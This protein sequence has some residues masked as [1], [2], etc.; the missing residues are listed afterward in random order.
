[1]PALRH[2]SNGHMTMDKW[3]YSSG[4][5]SSRAPGGHYRGHQASL[6]G[7]VGHIVFFA[8]TRQAVYNF[9]RTP[10]RDTSP[11]RPHFLMIEL[12]VSAP[13]GG[14]HYRICQGISHQARYCTP[15]GHL[16]GHHHQARLCA[17][18]GHLAVLTRFKYQ[19]QYQMSTKQAAANLPS[20]HLIVTTWRPSLPGTALSHSGHIR[21]A[22]LGHH[23][24]AI[25]RA[26]LSPGTAPS[27]QL[28]GTHPPGRA[29]IDLPVTPENL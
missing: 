13:P 7:H 11:G 29:I 16:G 21:Q 25:T 22:H 24:A 27:H 6:G 5:A 26:L 14:G 8:G 18:L 23:L 12:P 28:G 10:G 17:F 15:G 20:K 3:T 19:I 1:M 9:A 4:Q 2:A